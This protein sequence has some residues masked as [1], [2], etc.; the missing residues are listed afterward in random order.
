MKVTIIQTT[1][2]ILNEDRTLR[3]SII[4]ES[5]VITPAEGKALQNTKTG[6]IIKAKVCVNKKSKLN[7]YK[8]ID[9]PK[10]E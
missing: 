9:L 3:S 2:K 8:E 4:T 5:Y 10:E 1:T 6:E 7:M